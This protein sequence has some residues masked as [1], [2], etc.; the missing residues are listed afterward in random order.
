[1]DKNIVEF[2]VE[3]IGTFKAYK[4]E[5]PAK[6]MLDS[7]A[8][9]NRLAQLV[10]GRVE[11]AKMEATIRGKIKMDDPI[12]Q[13]IAQS[14]YHEYERA[15]FFVDADRLI[16]GMPVSFSLEKCTP[17][18]FDSLWLAWET[19]TGRFQSTDDGKAGEAAGASKAEAGEASPKP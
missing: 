19:A 9:R 3:G 15:K 13:D 10:G 11:L 6:T 7:Q 2:E 4:E 1:M 8:R 16:T 5:P 14:L 17:D 18:D 12:E